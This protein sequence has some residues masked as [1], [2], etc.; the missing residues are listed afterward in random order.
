[1]TKFTVLSVTSSSVVGET[2]E[3]VHKVFTLDMYPNLKVAKKGDVIDD[4]GETVA[5]ES[6]PPKNAKTASSGRSSTKSTT[7]QV[8][9]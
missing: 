9:M 4:A 8:L 7:N 3:G 6:K 5:L 1:M 2:K